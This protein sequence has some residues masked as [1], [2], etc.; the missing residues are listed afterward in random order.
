EEIKDKIREVS[1]HILNATKVENGASHIELMITDEGKVYPIEIGSRMG[2]DFIGSDLVQLS[3]GFDYLQAVLDIAL[4]QYTL[5]ESVQ[6]VAY[7]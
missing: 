5:P 7:A 1:Y 4:N 6:S 2:G 3:T